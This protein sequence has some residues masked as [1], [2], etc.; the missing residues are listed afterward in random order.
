[1]GGGEPQAQGCLSCNTTFLSDDRL[2]PSRDASV[3]GCCPNIFSQRRR[4]D[5]KK[6]IHVQR[7]I[8]ADGWRA[9]GSCPELMGTQ[10]DDR[11]RDEILE[12]V[13][14]LEE[15]NARHIGELEVYKKKVWSHLR[16]D[17]KGPFSSGDAKYF[18]RGF[19][20]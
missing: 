3:R 4:Y 11:K 1:M 14:L 8:N 7:A 19:L 18:A 12:G 20:P 2:L 15:S 16:N 10:Q 17:A 13:Q 9:S 5:L 6:I